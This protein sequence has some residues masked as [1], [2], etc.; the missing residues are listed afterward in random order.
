MEQFRTSLIDNYTGE[1]IRISPLAFITRA[2]VNA[3]KKYPNFNS[4][5]DAQNK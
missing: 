1:R 2:V 4:S 5:I 3:L